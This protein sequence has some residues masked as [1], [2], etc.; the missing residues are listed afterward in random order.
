MNSDTNTVVVPSHVENLL[1]EYAAEIGLHG[2]LTLENLIDSHRR[3]RERAQVS[4]EKL[5][6]EMKRGFDAGYKNGVE[7]ATKFNYLSREALRNMTLA[8]LAE[9]LSEDV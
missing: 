9:I 1:Q 8:K 6:Q 4:N 3:L 5:R 2:T 7:Q